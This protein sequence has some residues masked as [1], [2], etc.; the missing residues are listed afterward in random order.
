[1]ERHTS[2]AVKHPFHQKEPQ[3]MN[4]DR[5]LVSLRSRVS[6]DVV[7]ALHRSA[8]LGF[9]GSMPVDEQIDHALGFVAAAEDTL[10]GSPESVVDLGTGGGVPG[11]VLQSCWPTSKLVLM[12]GNERRTE[13]LAAELEAWSGGHKTAVVRG[14]AEE[15]AREATYRGEFVLVTARSF[16]K[17]AVTA[18]C[19]APLLGVSGVMVVSEP[20]G[21]QVEGRWPGEGLSEVGME[22]LTRYRF[23]DRY[24][25][26][27]LI[28]SGETPERYPRRVGIPGKRPLF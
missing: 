18:E 1:M 28:K 23:E 9:L 21:E 16:G 10:G 27:I 8:A 6:T 4:E 11:L 13:F 2:V 3:A 7:G 12:D 24:G 15:L 20:P 19:G 26:Q 14:R 22:R 5:F 25:Y 17:P